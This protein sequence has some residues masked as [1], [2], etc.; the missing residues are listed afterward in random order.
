MDLALFL[1]GSLKTTTRRA[2]EGNLLRR[3]HELLVAG[4]VTSYGFPQ[5]ME[6]CQLA[7]LWLPGV[8]VVWHTSIKLGRYAQ[9]LSHV[10]NP[11]SPA[12]FRTTTSRSLLVRTGTLLP[13]QQAIQWHRNQR[14]LFVFSHHL[15]LSDSSA[16]PSSPCL[17]NAYT[18]SS[19]RLLF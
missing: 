15:L 10:S 19:R 3:Y 5:L 7:V 1:F 16:G 9:H 4:G 18:R 8:K 6:D 14:V 11:I 13:L 2:A 12:Y 17:H